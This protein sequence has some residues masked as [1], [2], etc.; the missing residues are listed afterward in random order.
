MAKDPAINWYFDNW[1]G[2]TKLFTRHQKGCYIDLLSA[3]FHCG[4]LTVEN[5]K[6]ILGSDF[7]EWKVLQAKFKQ[8]ENGMFFNERIEH[9]LEKRLLEKQRKSQGGTTAMKKRWGDKNLTNSLNKNLTNSL[10]NSLGTEIETEIG[11]EV[12]KEVQEKIFAEAWQSAFDNLF[13]DKLKTK[14]GALDVKKE[15]EDFRF[16]C[17]SAKG[18][19]HSRDSDGL[20]LGFLKQLKGEETKTNFKNGKSKQLHDY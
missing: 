3:Q 4:H 11:F 7:A 13:I 2:G 10:T 20:R 8:D 14:Y 12:L 5:I 6:Q 17:D 16:K 9:E 15:L 1:D 18:E 19:Y